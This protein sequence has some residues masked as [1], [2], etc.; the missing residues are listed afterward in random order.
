MTESNFTATVLPEA[1]LSPLPAAGLSPLPEAG[2][3]PP[4]AGCPPD[5]GPLSF[6]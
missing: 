2:L 5:A 3:S 1:G 4:S 6:W